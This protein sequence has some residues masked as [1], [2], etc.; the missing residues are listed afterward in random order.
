MPG[1]SDSVPKASRGI[2][3]PSNVLWGRSQSDVTEP[4]PFPNLIKGDSLSVWSQWQ[5][6]RV[7]PSQGWTC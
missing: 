7:E 3:R 6:N 1:S 5:G 4:E 2:L